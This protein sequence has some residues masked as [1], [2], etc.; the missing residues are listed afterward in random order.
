MEPGGKNCETRKSGQECE[1][2][3]ELTVKGKLRKCKLTFKLRKR[4]FE[5]LGDTGVAML[6]LDL[7]RNIETGF[8]SEKENNKRRH[9]E[10][11]K[12]RQAMVWDIQQEHPHWGAWRVSKEM[13]KRGIKLHY[14]TIQVLLRKTAKKMKVDPKTIKKLYEMSDKYPEMSRSQKATILGIAGETAR[15]YLQIR[16]ELENDPDYSQFFSRD[17]SNESFSGCA[18]EAKTGKVSAA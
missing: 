4:L 16:S 5:L 9:L 15:N 8:C 12:K 6:I 11:T 17:G 10:R 1:R 14:S 7:Q 3:Q 2:K 13:E 18:G